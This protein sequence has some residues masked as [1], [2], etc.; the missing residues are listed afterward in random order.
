MS[1]HKGCRILVIEPVHTG[2]SSVL[3]VVFLGHPVQSRSRKK[4]RRSNFLEKYLVCGNK[5]RRKGN[6]CVQK[7][8]HH[9]G[10][11]KKKEFFLRYRKNIEREERRRKVGKPLKWKNFGR[12][13]CLQLWAI[14]FPLLFLLQIKISIWPFLGVS[15]I[16]QTHDGASLSS[17]WGYCCSIIHHSFG[18]LPINIFPRPN[19]GQWFWHKI[20]LRGQSWNKSDT[21]RHIFLLNVVHDPHLGFPCQ[22]PPPLPNNG[23]Y[24]RSSPAP[25]TFQLR[26]TGDNTTPGYPQCPQIPTWG[27]LGTTQQSWHD[28]CMHTCYLSILV[29]HPFIKACKSTPKSA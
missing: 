3:L 22:H 2:S 13:G 18:C 5:G 1:R 4:E 24:M 23:E 12:P 7:W 9:S 26:R 8:N 15:Q 6:Y 11:E 21:F 16:Q 28:A 29:H 19:W 27:K 17:N 25:M 20:P 14:W 10:E